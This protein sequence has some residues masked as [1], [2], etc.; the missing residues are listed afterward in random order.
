[1]EMKKQYL[2]KIQFAD[3][4]EDGRWYIAARL[5]P[6][7]KPGQRFYESLEEAKAG[8]NRLTKKFNKEYAYDANGNRRETRSIGGG[9]A[10]DIVIDRKLDEMNRIV[11]WSIQV[12]EVTPWEVVEN[13]K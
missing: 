9:F 8:L 7:A 1:M 10:A 5:D 13:N 3:G 2:V 6:M 11:N 4:V 12:R